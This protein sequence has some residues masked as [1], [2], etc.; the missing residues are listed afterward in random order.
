MVAILAVIILGATLFAFFAPFISTC[1]TAG[2]ALDCPPYGSCRL[3][4]CIHSSGYEPKI[5]SITYWLF[6]YGGTFVPNGP[7]WPTVYQVFYP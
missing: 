2:F 5:G 4:Y 3:P 7:F 6:G 1:H